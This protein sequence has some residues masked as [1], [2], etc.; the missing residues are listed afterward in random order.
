MALRP[1]AFWDGDG[2]PARAL[3]PLSALVSR[4]TA[5]R[6]AQPG[7]RAPVK[8]LCCGNAGVGGAGKTTVALDLGRRLLASGARVAFLTRGYGG[9]TRGVTRVAPGQADA[10]EVGDEA[11]LLAAVAPAY[12]GAD[13]AAAAQA[14]IADGATVLVM[15]D[16]LQNPGLVK[17]VSL[18]VVDG[19]A[20]FGNRRVL[21]AGPL[22]ESVAAAAVRCR[23]A[24]LIG[25]DEYGAL[26]AL[27]PALAVLRA[28]L[29]PCTALD[30]VRAV[31]FAGIGRPGKFFATVAQAGATVA[32]THAFPD[33]HPFRP[34]ELERL[35]R[36]AAGLGAQL[37]TTAKDAARLSPTWRAAVTV[38][39]V[40]VQWRD[41]AAL[42]ALLAELA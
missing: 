5:R 41:E 23:A 28:R 18:L 31:A 17:D 36:R 4:A 1:P 33:H 27:P 13:R 26:G 16:G 32:E 34:A 24:V 42:A 20:G 3:A 30:G 10:G 8:V 38:L 19:G 6:V 25:P 2:L 12:V 37:V 11:L 14:A 21:P 15:D 29:A 35:R 39:D 9:R 22:R 7:W 40:Q